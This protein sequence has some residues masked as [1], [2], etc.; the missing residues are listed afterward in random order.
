MFV[1]PDGRIV[2]IIVGIGLGVALE[3]LADYVENNNCSCSSGSSAAGY[4]S[5]AAAGG[6][7]GDASRTIP[8]ARSGLGGP[9]GTGGTSRLSRFLSGLNIRSPIKLPAPTLKVPTAVTK[10]VGRALGRL[11][12]IG[13]AGY[14][15]YNLYRIGRCLAK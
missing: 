10:N 9:S 1:D 11:A 14:A 2:P 7:L 3:G 8:Y 12:P 13:A 15:G 5:A 4:A 6:I